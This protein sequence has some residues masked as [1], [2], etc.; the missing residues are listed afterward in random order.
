[1]KEPAWL[2]HLID[3]RLA[4]IEESIGHAVPTTNIIMTPLTEP[5]PTATQR[6]LEQWDRSCDNCGRHCPPP[7]Q[8][9]TGH[10]VRTLRAGTRVYMT[11]GVCQRCQSAFED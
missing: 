9:Y 4:L 11:F 10:I 5:G 8:F 2:T 1:M 7:K 6:E 3:Q